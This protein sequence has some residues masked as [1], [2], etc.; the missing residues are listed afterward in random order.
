MRNFLIS[1]FIVALVLCGRLTAWGQDS[2]ERFTVATLN[3][4]GLPQKILMVKV[5]TDGPGN[6]GTARIGKYLMKKGYDLIFV[7][8]GKTP[9]V[10][11]QVIRKYMKEHLS[12]AGVL[13]DAGESH[14]KSARQ[15]YHKRTDEKAE[16]GDI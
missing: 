4:D 13:K 10:K 8:R 11:S 6:A 5:N 15:F 16:G 1:T 3:V 7:A 14:E 12:K 9:F 2:G